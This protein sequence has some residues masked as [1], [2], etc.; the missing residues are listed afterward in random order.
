[1]LSSILSKVNSKNKEFVG[2]SLSPNGVLEIVQVNRVDKTIQN[3]T[4]RYVSY[5]PITREL[6]SYDAFRS[7]LEAG[8]DALGLSPKSCN[9]V[10]SLPNVLFGISDSLPSMLTE[11]AEIAGVLISEVEDAYLFKKEEPVISWNVLATVGDFQKVAYTAIQESVLREIR[12]VF[13]GIGATLVSV[14]NAYSTL[15]GGLEFSGR[16]ANFIPKDTQYWNMVVITGSSLSIFNFNESTLTNYYEEAL[17]VKSY[18]ETEVY[19]EVAKRASDSLQSFAGSRILIISQTD[20]ISAEVMA[21]KIA[22]ETY[23]IEQNKFQQ[24]PL[25]EASLNILPNLVSQISVSGIGAAVD[26]ADGNPLKFNYL[27]SADGFK[28]VESPDLITIAGKSFELTIAKAKSITL[29]AVVVLAVFW[30]AI[31]GLI[32]LG[33]G[34]V[35]AQV[36]S[37]NNTEQKLQSE[38]SQYKQKPK[39]KIDISSSINVITDENRKKML[40]YDALSYGIPDNLWLEYF[41]TNTSGG[42][43]IKGVAMSSTD[44]TAFLKG[45]REVSGESDVSLSKLSIINEEDILNYNGSDLY[46]FELSS[47]S[48]VSGGSTD[49]VST[50]S[51]GDEEQSKSRSTR[52]RRNSTPPAEL[53]SLVPPVRIINN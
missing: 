36:D 20:D 22:G 31:Y 12:D 10:L 4:N 44:I 35:K 39:K 13:D 52:R 41:E 1:M 25:L 32:N 30:G 18:S 2:V 42:V 33:I 37:L 3:Y 29:L 5:N 26:Y 8:F 48:F 38:L 46:T 47:R 15:I 6:E 14:Q 27:Q 40:Y 9:V 17:A 53:P 50:S 49:V 19:T 21:T 23:Y 11:P 28:G 7:E 24:S 43:F 45:I 16:L 51:E 34:G